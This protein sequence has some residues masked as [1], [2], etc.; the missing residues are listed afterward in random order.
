[1]YKIHH[2]W[3]KFYTIFVRMGISFVQYPSQW[4]LKGISLSLIA[5]NKFPICH[6]ETMSS[7]EDSWKLL[8]CEEFFC[9]ELNGLAKTKLNIKSDIHG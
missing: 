6:H 3:D 4:W 2:T 7:I 9:D 8:I 1:M 5:E